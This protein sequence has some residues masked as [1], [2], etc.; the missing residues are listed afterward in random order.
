MKKLLVAMMVGALML[1]W[2]FG[3]RQVQ[4]G[5]PPTVDF[6]IEVATATCDTDG[7]ST[8]CNVP[9]GSQ[10]TVGVIMDSFSG[11]NGGGDYISWQAR[12][13]NSVGMPY[14]PRAGTTEIVWGLGV[15]PAETAGVDTYEASDWSM[16][17]SPWTP[18]GY[19]GPLMEVDYDCTTSPSAGH[20]VTMVHGISD[21]YLFDEYH[22]NIVD[23]G[24]TPNPD[25][26][27]TINCVPSV[28]GIVELLAGGDSSSSDYT[29]AIAAAAAGAVLAFAAGGWYA[30]RRWLS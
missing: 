24:P 22:Q 2:G 28:G 18:T 14:V 13:D 12:L 4:A 5:G 30:R 1:A 8:T 3:A 15:D 20:T 9:V 21:T 16:A 10:F 11:L 29:L 7:G 25:E 27:L 23:G 6:Y 26:V 17:I 19:L